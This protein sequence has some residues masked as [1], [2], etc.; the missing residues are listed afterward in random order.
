MPKIKKLVLEIGGKEIELTMEEA[1]ELKLIL[2]EIFQ[3][4]IIYV[5]PIPCPCPCEPYRQYP[6]D[7]WTSWSAGY[8]DNDCSFTLTNTK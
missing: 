5:P 4:N 7:T 2:G 6:Y 8:D 1:K 3:E